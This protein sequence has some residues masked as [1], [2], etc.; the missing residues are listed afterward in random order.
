MLAIW[1]LVGFVLLLGMVRQRHAM[2]KEKPPLQEKQVVELLG[3]PEQRAFEATL[4]DQI[5]GPTGF[6]VNVFATGLGQPRRITVA[7][8][9]T[10]Y[11]TRCETNDVVALYDSDSDGRANTVR[12]VVDHLAMV[13]SLGTAE[14]FE[15]FLHEFLLK[16]GCA[17]SGQPAGLAV[18]QDGALL[19]SD[20]TNGVIYRVTY[21]AEAA[22]W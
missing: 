14:R 21:Q 1:C 4:V 6:K 16:D 18:A 20:A 17:Y 22:R 2:E 9:S 13:H 8:D 19:I 5:Q 10:V 15:D 11:V 3:K 12:V 7:E